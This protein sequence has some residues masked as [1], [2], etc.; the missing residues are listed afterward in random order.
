MEL[1]ITIFLIQNKLTSLFDTGWSIIRLDNGIEV[2]FKFGDSLSQA[3][4]SPR[5]F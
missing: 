3:S 4:A 2:L 5:T 1:K